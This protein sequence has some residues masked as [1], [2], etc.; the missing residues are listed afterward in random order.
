MFNFC[1][2]LVC[3]F[4]LTTMLFAIPIYAQIDNCK[5]ENGRIVCEVSERD[6]YQ[7]GPIQVPNES[8]VVIRITD[9]SP[10]DN[11]VLTE[12][13]LTPITEP[14]PLTAMISLFTKLATGAALPSTLITQPQPT[15][16]PSPSPRPKPAGYDVNKLSGRIFDASDELD[17]SVTTELSTSK[18]IINRQ[19]TLLEDI[20]NLMSSPPR[21]NNEFN[22]GTAPSLILRLNSEL[23]NTK[24]MSSDEARSRYI[25][26]REQVKTVNEP[27]VVD[28]LNVLGEIAPKLTEL[29]VRYEAINSARS[30]FKTVVKILE[31]TQNAINAN[32]NPFVQDITDLIRYNQ[33][34]AKTAITCSNIITKKKT[35]N[36]QKIP[37]D[38]SYRRRD[39]NLSVSA[40][41]L[42]STIPKQK[43]GTTPIN[44][45]LNSS[46]A[47]TFRSDFAV[48][49]RAS[50]Q[51]IPFAFFSYR[52]KNFGDSSNPVK[53]P[54]FSLHFSAGVG[55]NPNSGTTE[56]E[57]FV[58]PSIGFK[59][60]LIHFGDHIGRFQKGF[61]G[62]FNIGDPV[63]ASFPSTLPIE[64]K[65]RHGFG[66][67]LSYKL[68]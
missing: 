56:V 43:L 39:S 64:K 30:L 40:G 68:F 26:L 52:V 12:T 11:C 10:F 41:P 7:L 20:N 2:K 24:D 25:S 60:F 33:N 61:K 28:I 62:G 3:C 27:I 8:K 19:K 22:T 67:S 21:N 18:A 66:I 17:R 42:L 47:P 45:G 48:I 34:R 50:Y 31:S 23:N 1:L 15:P 57:Y 14:D 53:P 55:A 46:G 36:E 38:I 65:Y 29:E 16:S 13:T 49:D 54:K 9:K 5:R 37:V 44:T 59:K 58:G 63:P 6:P 4:G 32:Q 35:F 51:I